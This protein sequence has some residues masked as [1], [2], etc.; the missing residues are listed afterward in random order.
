MAAANKIFIHDFDRDYQVSHYLPKIN[1]PIHFKNELEFMELYQGARYGSKEQ[2]NELRR[3]L[4]LNDTQEENPF[5]VSLFKM[6][7]DLS[8]AIFSGHFNPTL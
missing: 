3:K 7:I 2:K 1:G 4:Q 5:Y 6:R 8:S